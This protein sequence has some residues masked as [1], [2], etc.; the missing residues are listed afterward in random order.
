MLG[1]FSFISQFLWKQILELY[2]RQNLSC[3]MSLV[4]SENGGELKLEVTLYVDTPPTHSSHRWVMLHSEQENSWFR[5]KEKHNLIWSFLEECEM[6]LGNVRAIMVHKAL[7]CS[8]PLT[9]FFFPYLDEV[10]IKG[11]AQGILCHIFMGVKGL[12]QMCYYIQKGLFQ[13]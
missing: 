8:L 9:T 1:L 10:W 2:P 5:F 13:C 11:K 4:G 6:F 7:P 3:A 12:V